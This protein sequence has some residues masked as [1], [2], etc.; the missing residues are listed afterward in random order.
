MAKPII[1][2]IVILGFG[3]RHV[4]SELPLAS[5]PPFADILVTGIPRKAG[6]DPL[7]LPAESSVLR[8]LEEVRRMGGFKS[9]IY[10]IT[11]D[12]VQ[13]D[14][15]LSRRMDLRKMTL[16]AAEKTTFP[17]GTSIFVIEPPFNWE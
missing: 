10:M 13:G 14:R 3:C 12:T 9:G 17:A 8:V 16:Q 11:V 15:R 6:G 1:I 2:F 4:S 7:R 5:H